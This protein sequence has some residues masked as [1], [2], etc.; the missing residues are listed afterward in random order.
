MKRI[1]IVISYIAISWTVFYLLSFVW[2]GDSWG[3]FAAFFCVLGP[4]GL[5]YSNINGAIKTNRFDALQVD[6]N[7]SIPCYAF[8]NMY[9][10]TG[11][12]YT[13]VKKVS[14][15]TYIICLCSKSTLYFYE[16]SSSLM[17]QKEFN[18]EMC[19]DIDSELIAVSKSDVIKFNFHDLN[20]TSSDRI[21]NWVANKVGAHI[22]GY[23][24]NRVQTMVS[25]DAIVEIYFKHNNTLKALVFGIPESIASPFSIDFFSVL[26]DVIT[27]AHDY[28]SDC[29]EVIHDLNTD[30][31]HI[32]KAKNMIRGFCK[33][34]VK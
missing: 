11:G 6:Y 20:R 27:Q 3:I 33:A 12:K 7:A 32:R 18:Y 28:I 25:M 4:I 24:T 29:K 31:T 26:P 13:E 10:W 30:E 21:G 17:S 15:L 9:I 19:N 8:L 5:I 1:Y 23:F 16:C 14:K 22:Q 2:T 34:I